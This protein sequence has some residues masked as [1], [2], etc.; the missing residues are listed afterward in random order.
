MFAAGAKRLALRLV[1]DLRRTVWRMAYDPGAIDAALAAAVGD[2]AALIAELR[3]AFVEGATTAVQAM[4]AAANDADW[5]TA[6]WRLRGLAASF[7]AVRLMALAA[8]AADSGRRDPASI[9]K[10]ER[11]LTRL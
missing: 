2:D 8:A 11:A 3:M 5:R 9:A 4:R 1:N 10:L 6:A 7:G